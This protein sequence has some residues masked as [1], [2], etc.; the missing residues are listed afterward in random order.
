MKTSNNLVWRESARRCQR[1]VDAVRQRPEWN[2]EARRPV[3][4]CSART[5]AERRSQRPVDAVRQRPEW[6][7]ET[8]MFESGRTRFNKKGHPSDVLFVKRERETGLEP[9]A[10]TLARSCS[11]N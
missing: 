8:R 3:D 11:T 4:V 7:E 1:P 10:P 9:A 2:G 6:S 5:G